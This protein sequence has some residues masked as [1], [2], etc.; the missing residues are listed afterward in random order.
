MSANPFYSTPFWKGLRRAALRRDGHH[1][2]VPGCVAGASIVDH[3]ITRP[4]GVPF[5]CAE[6]T[7]SNLRSLCKTHD[8]QIKE[9]AA[10]RRKRNGRPVLRGC[11]ADGWP[12]GLSD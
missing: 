3:I 10:G 9:D 5:P 7:L 4:R 2:T 1:C 8:A 12:L 6:D 11:D